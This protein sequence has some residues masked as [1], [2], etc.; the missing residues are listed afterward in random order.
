MIV[1]FIYE[2]G[3]GVGANLLTLLLVILIRFLSKGWNQ[4]CLRFFGV[5][6]RRRLNVYYGCASIG[7]G[8]VGARE[9]Q[10]T[11][12]FAEL[13][14]LRIPGLTDGDSL[15][16]TIFLAAVKV[17]GLASCKDTK[18]SLEDSLIT[19]GSPR[20]TLASDVF[21]KRIEPAIS[22]HD[23]AI[24]F[25]GGKVEGDRSQ[26]VLVKKC[27]NGLAYFYAAGTDE[28]GTVAASRYLAEH[29][30]ELARKYPAGQS[31]FVRLQLN[32][33]DDQVHLLSE[34]LLE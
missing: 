5:Y 29:W 24:E 4:K 11:S 18:V 7:T 32:A 17:Q 3:I 19:L 20:Y 14:Q 30:K 16:R 26:A 31:F 6:K 12:R 8:W 21:E 22:V 13:F 9:S 28:P 1:G 27:R 33:D 23:D 2:L 34:G 10:E 25:P 15:L